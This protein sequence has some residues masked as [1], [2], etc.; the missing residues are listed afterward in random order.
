VFLTRND[1]VATA[2]DPVR[3]DLFASRAIGGDDPRTDREG[4][5]AR[6]LA[7]RQST[8]KAIGDSV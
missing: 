3:P 6:P 7:R 5:A 4:H 8:R 2:L 1:F